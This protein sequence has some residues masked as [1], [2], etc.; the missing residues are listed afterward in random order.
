MPSDIEMLARVTGLPEKELGD[1]VSLLADLDLITISGNKITCQDLD[2]YRQSLETRSKKL[3]DSGKLGAK[4]S[5]SKR[6][7]SAKNEA[8]TLTATL[9]ASPSLPPQQNGG[10]LV[11]CSLGELSQN[12]LTSN[13]GLPSDVDDWL[14]KYDQEPPFD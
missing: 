5:N 12:Q 4:I 1:S 11:E 10:L 8:A 7:N 6:R 2:D 13:S 14:S 9:T 3:S